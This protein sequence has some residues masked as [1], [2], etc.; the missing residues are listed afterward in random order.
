ML[1][2]LRRFS[3]R[4]SQVTSGTLVS[5]LEEITPPGA[6]APFVPL[7]ERDVFAVQKLTE[8]ERGRFDIL[9]LV[10]DSEG[11]IPGSQREKQGCAAP[12]QR[13][14]DAQALSHLLA[15]CSREKRNVEQHAGKDLVRFPFIAARFGHFQRHE[16]CKCAIKRAQEWP[17]HIPDGFKEVVCL[18]GSPQA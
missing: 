11:I 5:N 18:A 9:L 15:E 1:V 10:L 12:R 14:K 4:K 13:V 2:S 3:M 6:A 8:K 16:R 7:F 17:L